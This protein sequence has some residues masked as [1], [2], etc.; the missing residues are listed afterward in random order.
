MRCLKEDV[1]LDRYC[2]NA[3]LL[4]IG[5]EEG[6]KSSLEDSDLPFIL[7]FIPPRFGDRLEGG[8]LNRFDPIPSLCVLVSFLLTPLE[9]LQ[10]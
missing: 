7:F 5:K 6:G 9:G 8:R 2:A 1:L 4:M 3:G 10:R